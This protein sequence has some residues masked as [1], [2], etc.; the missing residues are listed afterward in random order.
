M[1]LIGRKFPHTVDRSEFCNGNDG[2]PKKV[3]KPTGPVKCV[4]WGVFRWFRVL[5]LDESIKERGPTIVLVILLLCLLVPALEHTFE[6]FD[7]TPKIQKE[8]ARVLSFESAGAVRNS[9]KVPKL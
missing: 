2:Q 6:N 8:K 1:P 4:L 5:R 7:G 9:C 3:N